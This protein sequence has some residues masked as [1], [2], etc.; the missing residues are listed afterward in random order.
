MIM[1]ELASNKPPFTEYTHDIELAFK[2][3]D[4]ARPKVIKG[5]PNFYAKIM[6]QCWNPDPLQR[7]DASLLP[8]MFEEMMELCKIIDHDKVDSL[9]NSLSQTNFI[10]DQ[11]DV[12]I[13]N[14]ITDQND[15]SINPGIQI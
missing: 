15:I 14:S 10:T 1:W 12:S 13:T 8:K 6:K 7:P 11:N 9:T 4:G 3:L 2:I 5:M